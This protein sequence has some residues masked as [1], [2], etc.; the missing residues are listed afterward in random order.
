M[1][2]LR[3]I[4][5]LIF[6]G[7]LT[8][9]VFSQQFEDPP[10]NFY[11]GAQVGANRYLVDYPSGSQGVAVSP[12]HV[13]VGYQIS[14]R[15]A[16]QLGV[17]RR[18]RQQYVGSTTVAPVPGGPA[19]RFESDW[20]TT[21]VPLLGRY[22]LTSKASRRFKVDVVGGVALVRSRYRYNRTVAQNGVVIEQENIDSRV[23]DPYLTA[24]VGTRYG[25]NRKLALTFDAQLNRL[26]RTVRTDPKESF[27][28]Y[29]SLAVGLRY[30]F[31]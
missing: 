27:L 17:G 2:Y 3:H 29:S 7:L 20:W 11:V 22:T 31:R 28:G 16:V 5:T 8:H 10:D 19:S 26:P 12:V 1:M 25:L 18:R 6:A 4:V 23:T 21:H 15:L 30:T 24:G 14:P 13:Q 9:P